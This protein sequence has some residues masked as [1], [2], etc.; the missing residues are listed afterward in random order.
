MS[1]LKEREKFHIGDRV[2]TR[3]TAEA[4]FSGQ[5]G[6]PRCTFG[7]GD[8]GIISAIKVPDEEGGHY[9][10]VDF[11]KEG[12]LYG[13]GTLPWRVPVSYEN[14]VLLSCPHPVPIPDES[15]VPL[16]VAALGAER[17]THF[18]FLSYP[19]PRRVVAVTSAIKQLADEKKIA[20]SY[21]VTAFC[22]GYLLQESY[23]LSDEV[24]RQLLS[25]KV[26]DLVA[27]IERANQH[28]ATTNPVTDGDFIDFVRRSLQSYPKK[29]S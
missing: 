28:C 18:D 5:H 15:I 9:C 16:V 29:E 19:V 20:D 2:T 3:T 11:Q 7:Y 12:I 24:I 14:L 23:D 8:E 22:T 13:D 21:Y 6:N 4:Y 1:K 27:F 26:R 17:V 25:M 10:C